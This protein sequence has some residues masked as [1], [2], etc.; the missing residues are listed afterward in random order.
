MDKYKDLVAKIEEHNRNYYVLDNPTISDY[1]YDM[2]MRELREMEEANPALV[3]PASPTQRVGGEAL[4]TFGKVTHAVQMGSLQDVF[5]HDELRAFDK[6]VA[7]STHA[8]TYVA[9]PKVDGLSVALQYEG[10]IFVRGATRGDGFVGEDV[11]ANL[12]T[13]HSVP[14]QLTEA[15]D[16]TVR[17]EVF[18]SRSS[19]ERLLERQEERGEALS[20]NPRNAAAGALRQKNPAVTAERE[21]DIFVFNV[22]SGGAELTSH[23]ESLEYMARL[24]FKVIQ[25]YKVTSDIEAVIEHIERIGETRY[26]LPYDIDGAV[27]KVNDFAQREEIGYTS[28]VPKW[29]AAYKYPPEE[30]E[31]ML[32]EIEVNV[33]RTGAL[34]PVAI[35]EPVTLAGTTVS[36]ASL[37]NQDIIDSLGVYIGARIVVRKAGDIIPEVVRVI[38]P[39]TP[40]QIPE[41]CPELA[42]QAQTLRNLEHF[43]SR[44]AMNID[45]LGEAIVRILA[46]NKLIATV[47]DLYRLT[48]D[49]LMSLEGFKAKSAENLIGAIEKS[50]ENPLNRVLYAIGIKGIGRSASVALCE[51][52]GDMDSIMAAEVESIKAI[53]KFGDILAENLYSAMRDDDTIR[54]IEDLRALGLKMEYSRKAK[55]DKLAGLTFVITGTLPT[56]KRE[57][58]KSLIESLGG[59][60]AGS[61][62]KK[63]SYVVAGEEAGSKL[64]KAQSL[65]VAVLSEEDLIKLAES[66]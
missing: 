66:S 56:M 33:G 12:R 62:S 9:E 15:V 10:G 54:L 28:K 27:V 5:S 3:S 16:I 24:G 63:T 29:A 58:A 51:E 42:A 36:R 8:P 48:A 50:K 26:S 44:D 39:G 38:N 7:A 57:E 13:V 30:K 22:Q 23:Q 11:T 4:N 55:S 53:E 31:T 37:H 14:L 6:R 32:T 2:L 60:C 65:G 34:T 1:D 45:G 47:A 61:V 20:K 17:G 52:F 25:G 64:T 41:M 46:E 40:Y 49:D 21:L 35:F 18:M 59:K 43:A 19:F